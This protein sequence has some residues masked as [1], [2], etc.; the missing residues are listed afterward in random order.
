[1]FQYYRNVFRSAVFNELLDYLNFQKPRLGF[2]QTTYVL[3]QP[4]V[5][6][7]FQFSNFPL[8]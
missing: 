5:L 2:F 3:E 4:P 7:L 8:Q 6:G 1:M